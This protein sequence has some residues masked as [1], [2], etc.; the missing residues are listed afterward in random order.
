MDKE[1]RLQNLLS[2]VKAKEKSPEVFRFEYKKCC[3][4]FPFNSR[5]PERPN[6][7]N[8]FDGVVGAYTRCI[9]GMSANASIDVT[10]LINDILK[11]VEISNDEDKQAFKEIVSK[12]IFT[13]DGKLNVFSMPVFKY[14]LFSP[15]SKEKKGESSIGEY[16]SLIHI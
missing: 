16:L 3:D 10:T 15:T 13:V 2:L 9:C 1:A 4:L 8:G 6:F 5:N 7:V 14:C 12:F 11:K